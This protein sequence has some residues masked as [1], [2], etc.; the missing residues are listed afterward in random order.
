MVNRGLR[1]VPL[2]RIFPG[3]G[4]Q[5]PMQRNKL[6][7][8]SCHG[9]PVPFG[10]GHGT[11]KARRVAAAGLWQGRQYGGTTC[12]LGG[13]GSAWRYGAGQAEDAGARS[14]AWA[15]SRP[16]LTASVEGCKIAENRKIINYINDLRAISYRLTGLTAFLRGGLLRSHGP[17][18]TRSIFLYRHQVKSYRGR[19]RR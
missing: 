8:E 7:E 4:A 14:S 11:K 9:D 6:D 15:P 1:A 3:C 5:K 18:A 10:P 2:R 12:R 13:H 19:R 17:R 16:S